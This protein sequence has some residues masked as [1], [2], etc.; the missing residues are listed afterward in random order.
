MPSSYAQARPQLL[1]PH[2]P[3]LHHHCLVGVQGPAIVCGHRT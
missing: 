1:L 2:L 3:H